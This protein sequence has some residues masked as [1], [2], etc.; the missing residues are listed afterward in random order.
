MVL[1]FMMFFN[2]FGHLVCNLGEISTRINCRMLSKFHNCC[3]FFTCGYLKIQSTPSSF[4]SVFCVCAHESVWLLSRGWWWWRRLEGAIIKSC[5]LN[6]LHHHHHRRCRRRFFLCCRS[7]RPQSA[8]F[9]AVSQ[10]R[11]GGTGRGAEQSSLGSACLP[12]SSPSCWCVSV[13]SHRVQ[14]SLLIPAALANLH[15][16]W[17]YSPLHNPS[18]STHRTPLH[19]PSSINAA[20]FP[21]PTSTF[22][23][24]IF[25]DSTW[26]C[27]IH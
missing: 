6:H 1:T 26:T 3:H 21:P 2:N 10:L 4:L 27:C 17:R 22:I 7:L 9:Q 8:P 13:F 20:H 12:P 11:G 15:P 24:F 16:L 23:Y 18:A 14:G 19:C 5:F 25:F